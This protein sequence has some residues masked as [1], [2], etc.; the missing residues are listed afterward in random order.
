[1]FGFRLI[2][3]L[4]LNVKPMSIKEY[5]FYLKSIKPKF[6]V[7]EIFK[8]KP[9][10]H[11]VSGSPLLDIAAYFR[12]NL[13]RVSVPSPIAIDILMDTMARDRAHMYLFTV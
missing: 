12:A 1:M 11:H 7:P 8:W 5:S 6:E 3:L 9:I 13:D 10:G 4:T 2:I